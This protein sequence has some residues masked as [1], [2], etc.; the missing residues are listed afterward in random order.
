MK[1]V[2]EIYQ[3]IAGSKELQEELKAASEETVKAF[4]TKHGCEADVK[5]FLSLV[6]MHNRC[7]IT[8]A[9]ADVVAGGLPPSY[10]Q[11]QDGDKK[12]PSVF[13]PV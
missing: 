1:T 2:E 10:I 12:G 3:E 11:E 8:D 7:E 9:E 5:A 4:L 13:L 6:S